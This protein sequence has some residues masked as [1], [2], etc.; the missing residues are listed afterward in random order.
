MNQSCKHYYTIIIDGKQ[1][2]K[3]DLCEDKLIQRSILLAGKYPNR[4]FPPTNVCF[5]ENEEQPEC[6]FYE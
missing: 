4:R 6:P 2:R 1:V 3:C 5:F